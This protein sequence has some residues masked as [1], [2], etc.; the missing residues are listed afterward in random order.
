MAGEQLIEGEIAMTVQC[1][2]ENTGADG[3]AI[4]LLQKDLMQ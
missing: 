4:S 1:A 2:K 3:V